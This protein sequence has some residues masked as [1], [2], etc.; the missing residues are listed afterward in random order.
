M[1]KKWAEPPKPFDGTFSG[2]WGGPPD[3]TPMRDRRPSGAPGGY[4]SP[5]PEVTVCKHGKG[6]CE[7]CG[8]TNRRDVKHKTT[9]GKGVVGKLSRP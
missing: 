9:G 8:T 6:S 2:C 7:A 1:K 4:D 5:Q 3:D